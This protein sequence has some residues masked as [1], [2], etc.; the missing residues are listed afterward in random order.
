MK[1]YVLILATALFAAGPVATGS[2]VAKDTV[3]AKKLFGGKRLPADL[4][5]RSV[6]F[7]SRGCLAGAK[8]MPVDGP[9]WQAMR[10]SR[11][12]VW[13]HPVLI[14]YLQWL[15]R[16]AARKDG[17]PGL[18]VG[19]LSQPR[20]GP[21][22]TGHSSHQVG[23]D[24]D[25]WLTPM[26]NR[27]LSRR[28][29]ETMSAVAVTKGGP[30]R[31]YAK[32]W[33]DAHFRLI[34]RAAS[35]GKVERIL[36]APGIKKKLCETE[37]GNKAWLRKVRPYWG[38]NYHMHIRMSCPKG[39]SG[40][41]SQ[42]PPPNDHGC[43]EHLAWW[44]SKAPYA[45]PKKPPKKVKPK[46]PMTM[47]G[48]PSDCRKILAAAEKTNVAYVSDNNWTGPDV[49]MEGKGASKTIPAFRSFRLPKARPTR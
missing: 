12:R 33:T 36:V 48:L 16:E 9:H 28:E 31:V 30:N 26:P 18:L 1:R 6:G 3:P 23:L 32:V 35:H 27:T 17:W 49:P 7:Y 34:K 22:L 41:K 47:G 25:I 11:N 46:P 2:V 40:C 15:A 21:M 39:S 38:H 19:D 42:K 20:G 5:A 37:K 43:G 24:A 4:K 14:D 8:A 13:G 10:L 29:R 45:D 44:M